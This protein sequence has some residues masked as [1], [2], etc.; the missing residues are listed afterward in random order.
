MPVEP[1][2]EACLHHPDVAMMREHNTFRRAGRTGRVE[3]HRRLGWPWHD[4]FERSRIQ[5]ILKAIIATAAENHSRQAGRTIGVTR[6]VAEHQFRSAVL[7]NEMD[8]LARKAVVHRHRDEARAHDAVVGGE[9]FG[10]VHRQDR[11][12]V[13]AL[14]ATLDQR[15]RDAHAHGVELGIGVLAR[16]LLAAEVDD[17]DLGEIATADNQVTEIGGI[18]P[19]ARRIMPSAAEAARCSTCPA[20]L[21]A[22]CPRR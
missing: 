9:I 1:G 2:R 17:R 14:E 5:E 12:A 7:D 13:A 6:P 10:A 8:G 21:P 19:S 3:K 20:H 4:R 22:A 16:R 11:D 18:E 15:A